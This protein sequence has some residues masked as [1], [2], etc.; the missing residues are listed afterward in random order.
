MVD[1]AIRNVKVLDGSGAEAFDADVEVDDGRILS[2]GRAGK[3]EREIDGQGACLAPGFIDTHA[4][5][6]GAF[7]RHPGMPFKLAQGV[8][9]VVSGNCGFSA[10][11]QDPERDSVAAS[12]GILAGLEGEFKDLSGYFGAALALSPAINNMMLVGHNTVRT[13]A[14]GMQQREPTASELGVMRGHVECALEQGACG[15]STGLIYR[16]GRWSVTEEVVALAKLAKPFD[17]LYTTHMRNEGDKLLESVEETL[18]IGLA[19]DVHV[20]ISHH[21]SA[22]RANWGKVKDSLARVDA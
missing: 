9:S 21:K 15:F 20:H 3:A 6:D 14:M 7:F 12:G 4:H 13:L 16:P 22:G 1:L 10:I 19:S 5:D 8:T 17:A 2:V 11:P 18:H